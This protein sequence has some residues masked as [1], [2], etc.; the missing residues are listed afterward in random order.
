[1][2]KLYLYEWKKLFRQRSFL[3]FTLVLLLGNVFT[4]VQYEK[5]T[6]SYLYFYQSKQDWQKY[7]NG[8]KDVTQAEYYQ[9]LT[10]EAENYV[11]SYQYFLK[12]IPEQAEKLKKTGSY[13]N[14][15]T[16]LYRNLV[17]TVDDYKGLSADGVQA[18][19]GIGVK[20]L[21]AYQYG[22]YFQLIFVFVL[23]YFVIS[24]ERKK[25]LFLLSKG[26]ERGHVPLAAAKLLTMLS[27]GILYGL[28]QECST[29]SVLGYF[30]GYGNL[31][32]NIQSISLFRDC[33][34][35]VTIAQAMMLLLVAR[36]FIG[37]LCTLLMF[38]LTI[39]LRREGAALIIYAGVIGIEMFLN[40]TVR[41]SSPLNTAKCVN[42]FFFWDMKNLFGIY[43]N[44]N[45]FGYP[46]GKSLVMLIVGGILA[47]VFLGVGL[48][49]FSS[50][51]Q[52]SSGNL[53]E[54]IREKIAKITAFQWHHTSVYRFE[55]R[56]VLYQQKRIFLFLVLLIWC[57]FAVRDT[58]KPV[59]YDDPAEGEYH[60]ILSQVSGPVTEDSLNYIADQRQELD[61]MYEELAELKKENG[62][63]AEFK[64]DLLMHETDIREDGVSLVEEQRDQLLEKPGDISGKF[65]VDEKS[66]LSVFYDYK[67][68]LTAF[69]IGT[70][71]LVLWVSE[72]EVSDERKGLYSLLYTTK[73]GKK[74]IWQKKRHVGITGM[75]W[76][77][78]C[79]FLPQ[80]L[81]YYR[82]DG[83]QSGAQKLSYFTQ[84]EWSTSLWLEI[85]ILFL[86][87][88]KIGLFVLLFALLLMLI[89]RV[90]NTSIIIGAGVGGIGLVILFLW[91]F[92]IDLTIFLLGMMSP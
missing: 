7:T 46:I 56:K 75:I 52:I 39:S 25:G 59:F 71:A 72:M 83:F 19:L 17:K 69:M 61:A 31:S 80:F 42:V 47:G 18:E 76:C 53:L 82:I 85:G 20:Q 15:N 4:L 26:T 92:H 91:Y 63:M 8:E 12:Q 68:D 21:A 24:E 64:R 79:M 89:K 49:R 67:Y 84:T 38:C 23:S 41:I 43:L 86:F 48:Y 2:R 54:E 5:Q 11:S 57:V 78:L 37:V 35:S 32:G 58:M 3:F 88:L 90:H 9:Y 87:L 44:L 74:K 29:F 51:C 36:I 16:Y 81:R 70:I 6:D 50:S 28:L 77:M 65:W 27:A 14:P 40:Q 10:E 13:Q 60:R 22:I 33:S 1:M 34:I 73:A 55:L 45:L 66:Y 62:S 30:Y